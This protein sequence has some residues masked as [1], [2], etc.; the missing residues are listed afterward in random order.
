LSIEGTHELGPDNA[1]LT[2]RTERTGAVAKAGHDLL[3]VV[4]AWEGTL[5]LGDTPSVSLV[6]ESKTFKVLEGSGGVQALGD[7]D[8]AN[9]EQTIDD[10]VLHKRKIKFNSTDVQ[11]DGDRI[12]VTGDLRMNMNTNPVT[13]DLA[14]G[15]DGR[16]SGSAVVK[17]SDW[18]LT[19]YTALFGAL[20]VADE[21]VVGIET[22]PLS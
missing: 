11:V 15:D 19:P 6:A 12:T 8:K 13:F 3:L 1:R 22:E 7:D 2:V 14:V 10:E 9:I 21:V 20:K 17:Q 18:G 16:V 5:A 4:Q